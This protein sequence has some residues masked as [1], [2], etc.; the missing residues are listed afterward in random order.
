MVKFN[1]VWLFRP[2]KPRLLI[3]AIPTKFVEIAFW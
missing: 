1:K 3:Y 2:T